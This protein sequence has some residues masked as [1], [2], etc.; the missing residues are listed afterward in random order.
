M[1]FKLYAARMCNI[2][3]AKFP[4]FEGFLAQEIE[5]PDPQWS[6]DHYNGRN[7]YTVVMSRQFFIRSVRV[8]SP[9]RADKFD[10]LIRIPT[11]RQIRSIFDEFR[12]AY[13]NVQK[14]LVSSPATIDV[15]PLPSGKPASFSGGVGN[16]T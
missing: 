6:Q 5:Q 9:L 1:T 7:Y 15:K 10:A 2:T 12:D 4:E 16:F 13:E 11:Q 8:R 3:G 14:T